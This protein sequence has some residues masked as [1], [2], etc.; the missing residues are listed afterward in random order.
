MTAKLPIL[1]VASRCVLAFALIGS[2]TAGE[3][4]ATDIISVGDTGIR[5]A[6]YNILASPS[7]DRVEKE[8][9]A[10]RPK[11]GTFW[12]GPYWKAEKTV[13]YY[14][15]SLTLRVEGPRD[16]VH[17]TINMPICATPTSYA[18]REVMTSGPLWTKKVAVPGGQLFLCEEEGMLTTQYALEGRFPSSAEKLTALLNEIETHRETM[19][20][21]SCDVLDSIKA[22]ARGLEKKWAE[23]QRRLEEA[24][25][26]ANV[27]AYFQSLSAFELKIQTQML[28]LDQFGDMTILQMIPLAESNVAQHLWEEMHPS[29]LEYLVPGAEKMPQRKLLRAL[30]DN[31]MYMSEVALKVARMCAGELQRKAFGYWE[32]QSERIAETMTPAQAA[33]LFK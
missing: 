16:D 12:P 33:E 2:A 15:Y 28:L 22:E 20:R 23:R 7:A 4:T 8:L 17:M 31:P 26:E 25:R 6:G 24:R 10:F 27:L 32:Q 13:G 3:L 29:T 18:R 5:E 9:A 30:M 21:A 1:T 19:Y 11:P 14:L